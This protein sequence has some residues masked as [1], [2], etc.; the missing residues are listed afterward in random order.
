MEFNIRDEEQKAL[1]KVNE[2]IRK[3]DPIK[4]ELMLKYSE[5]DCM[6]TICVG[7]YNNLK[8]TRYSASTKKMRPN[9]F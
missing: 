1:L 5:K 2:N 9:L 4:S 8:K 3:V 6:N 7:N